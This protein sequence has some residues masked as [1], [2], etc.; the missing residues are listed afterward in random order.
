IPQLSAVPPADYYTR[1]GIGSDR[2]LEVPAN[3]ADLLGAF[4]SLSREHRDA[5]LRACF[6]FQHAKMIHSYSRSAAFTAVVSAIEAL[7]PG[8]KGPEVCEKCGRPIGVGPTKLFMEFVERFAPG[9]ASEADRRKLYSIRS[10]LS[11]GGSLLPSDR[12]TWSPH[13]TPARIEE[14]D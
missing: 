1:S 6:W 5:F 9:G 2:V 10:A 12:R 13:L 7:M 11:H 4:F 8:V 14:W 3:L